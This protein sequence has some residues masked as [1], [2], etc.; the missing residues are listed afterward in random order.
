MMQR[1][2]KLVMPGD[3]KQIGGA[4]DGRPPDPTVTGQSVC[5]TAADR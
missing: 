2:R 5:L 3:E 4:P 1:W